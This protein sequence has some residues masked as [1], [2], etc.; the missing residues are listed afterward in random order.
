MKGLSF[1]DITLLPA[2]FSRVR[3]RKDVNPTENFFGVPRLPIIS[4][5]MDTVYSI[6][7]GKETL[8]HNG[9][10]T[11][12]RFCSIEEQLRMF[13]NSYKLMNFSAW[14]AVGVGKLE[15]E[16]AKS[17]YDNGCMTFI[18]DVANAAS[19]HVV[20]QFKALRQIVPG[21]MI[22]VGNFDNKN[23]I[24]D[25]NYFAGQPADM[26]KSGVGNG[27]QCSTGIVTGV[28]TPTVSCLLS[29]VDSGFPVILDG[30]IKSSGDFCKAIALGAKAVMMGRQF[31][32]CV[33][34]GATGYHKTQTTY[35]ETRNELEITHKKYRG[36]A[37]QSSYVTQGKTDW[38]RAPE[39]EESFIPVTGTVEQF[40]QN[41]EGALRSSM[42]YLNSNDLTEYRERA[43]YL[44]IST[45]S[46][47]EKLPNKG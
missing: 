19:L 41:Y 12:H 40:L 38:N 42:S 21:A 39:G 10:T 24:K 30:G 14:C 31:A 5:N 34:S 33:E 37:S 23:Q 3:S 26:Y 44:E 27:S 35:H 43:K 2:D 11:I 18:L 7:L 47:L 20:D 32:G 9:I 6:E 25:F 29:C 8:K 13:Q 1:N 15:L 46:Y 36:S 22:V 4:S 16:R 45:S 17:L 28:G